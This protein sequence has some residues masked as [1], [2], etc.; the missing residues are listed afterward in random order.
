M[1][2]E[3]KF[4]PITLTDE[5]GNETQYDVIFVKELDG[6]TYYVLLPLDDND[7][8]DYVVLKYT[9]QDGEPYLITIDDDDEFD[10]V[11]DAIEDELFVDDDDTEED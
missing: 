4:D 5:D 3:N 1:S 11:A 7:E 6:N 8:E 2:E 10:R 9:E